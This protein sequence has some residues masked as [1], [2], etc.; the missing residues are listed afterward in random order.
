MDK[1]LIDIDN[2]TPGAITRQIVQF[3]IPKCALYQGTNENTYSILQVNKHFNK[4]MHN[5]CKIN[6]F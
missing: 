5:K 3:L 2:K 1:I 4:I 6:T